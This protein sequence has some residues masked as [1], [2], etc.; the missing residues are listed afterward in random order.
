[1]LI[2]EILGEALIEF[3]GGLADHMRTRKRR[4]KKQ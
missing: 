1:M 4:R 2:Y 3:F